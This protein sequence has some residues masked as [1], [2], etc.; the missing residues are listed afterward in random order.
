MTLPTNPIVLIPSRLASTRLPNK[1]LADIH[2]DPMIV[3]VWRRAME[4]EIGR[5]VVAAAEIEI[6]NAIKAAGGEAVITRADHA[7]GS[8]R[9]Y[10]AL[11]SLDPAREHDAIVN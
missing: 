9:I 11:S 1:P 10:E 8:D 4:A 5:V 3:H 2:G 7:S 6:V